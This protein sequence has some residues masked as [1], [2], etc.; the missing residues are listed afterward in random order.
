MKEI[1]KTNEE[2]CT[3]CN[4]CVR[5]CPMEMANITY[6]DDA[7]KIKVKVDETKCIA[8]GRCVS[9]CK[10]D[11][12]TFYD[13]TQLFFHDLAEGIP[14]SIMTAPSIRTNIPEYK[15]MFTWLKK[16]GV[17]CIYD[18]SFGADI[19][20]WGHVR[21]LEQAGATPIITQP[22]PVIVT[23]CE[24][25]QHNLLANLSPIH[26]PMACASVY[27][28]EYKGISD[29]I[30]ALSPCIAKTNEF[31]ETGLAQY[32]ITFSK[33]VEYLHKENIELPA[34]ETG[35]DHIASGL[36]SLFPMPGGLKENI[37]FFLGNKFHIFHAEGFN[38]YSKLNTFAET[39]A[40]ILPDVFD[41]LNCIEGCNVGPASL[42][43][44][45]VF[46]IDKTMDNS[47]KAATEN[48]KREYY[49]AV[50][51]TFDDTLDIKHFMREYKAVDTPIPLLSYEDIG[52]AFEQLGK[53]DEVQKNVNCGA[54]G[55]DSC[56]KMARKIALGV[57]IPLNCVTRT[58]DIA[59]E[60][61]IKNFYTL[62]QFETIWKNVESGIAIIDAETRT[63]LDVNPATLR[64]FAETRENMIG[65]SCEDFF[66]VNNGCP[67]CPLFNICQD[68][69][70]VERE[71][72]RPDGKK[73]TVMKSVSK[74]HFHGRPAV[75][76]SLSDVSYIKE[77]EE[78]QRMLNV[79]EQASKAKSAFLA[80]MSHEIRTP[81]NAIIGMTSIGKAAADADKKSY[82]L[83][84]IDD[85]SKH[86]LGIINDILDM[87]KIEAGRFELSPTEFSFEKMLQRVVNI[88]H[89]RI[90]EKGQTLSVHFDRTIPPALLGDE[91]RLAQVITNLVGNA[92]KFT[93]E[94]GTI[95][96][97]TLLLKEEESVCTIKISVTDTGI[98]I[99]PEQQKRLFHSFQQAE[100]STANK[101]GGTGLGLAIS[102]SIVEMMGGRIWIESELGKGATFAFTI[103]VKHLEGR[104]KEFHDWSNI[105]TLVVDD[106]PA[107]LEYFG[108]IMKGFGAF[109]DTAASG[110]EALRL[111]VRNGA[112]D[113]YFVD[114]RLP[115]IDGIELTETLKAKKKEAGNYFVIMMSATEW[116]LIED[117][118]KKAGVD[119]FISKPLFPSAIADVINE[120]FGKDQLQ[121]ENPAQGAAVTF[122]GRHILLAEDVDINREI[123]MALLEPTRMTIDIAEN[124]AEAVRMFSEAPDKYDMI[125]MDVQMPE[126]DGYEATRRIRALGTPKA[127]NIPIIAMTANVF[128]EDIERCIAA[129]M[130]SHI[131][132]PINF[133]EVLDKLKT[134]LAQGEK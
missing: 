79:A 37:E 67:I 35:F 18:V 132:K 109:C 52:K 54:C 78:H 16:M 117:D 76:E 83:E 8:C 19:S 42:G 114:W 123:V 20:I 131:G 46:E 5:E 25:Y 34:E 11:A 73:I 124:G 126:M 113:V 56:F 40:E 21:Y 72:T 118:A 105:R 39:R 110:E 121:A 70:K 71:I 4:R 112:Y 87:S 99:S 94:K 82:C 102:K 111:I 28:K 107:T 57:N 119:K 64:M 26:S 97:G 6:Q 129:G 101:F 50:Y 7:G 27:M 69:D 75:L 15:R 85:A 104:Q 68:V 108:E 128:R 12:R 134:Y 58:M 120:C 95:S 84:R 80:N 125:L 51:K 24:K 31:E 23:Y 103:Q 133:D 17:K 55:S 91:Q 74:V 22:C 77:A 100:S 13:D 96:I 61:Q 9:A 32:N 127:A 2:L 86:L 130:N 98:G 59:R 29:R 48:R 45:S 60:E 89:P 49:D 92:V 81:M 66:R 43:N 41:V 65:K 14:I 47:R 62:Q 38:V 3:G 90:N 36:G 63:I 44:R 53:T 116:S 106:D 30:A 1:I 93:P 33:L 10:H 115:G 122:E 88:N